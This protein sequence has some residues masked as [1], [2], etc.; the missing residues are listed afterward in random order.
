[1]PKALSFQ[2]IINLKILMRYFTFAPSVPS[3]QTPVYIFHSTFQFLLATFQIF[4]THVW[5]MATILV[6]AAPGY[7]RLSQSQIDD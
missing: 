5:L 6:Y 7:L 1:M 3:L 4:N 2:H